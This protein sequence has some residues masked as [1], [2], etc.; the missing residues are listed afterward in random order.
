M[1]EYSPL[2]KKEEFFYSAIKRLLV[3]VTATR[4]G[5]AAART[6]IGAAARRAATAPAAFVFAARLATP[7]YNTLTR[8]ATTRH[9]YRFNYLVL[10]SATLPHR[11]ENE[12]REMLVL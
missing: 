4:T 9:A 10:L 12:N 7:L 2:V 5:I 6:T 1:P 8:R 3:T 11:N